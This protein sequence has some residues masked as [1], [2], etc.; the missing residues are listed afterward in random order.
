MTC[1]SCGHQQGTGKFC[2]KCGAKLIEENIHPEVAATVSAPVHSAATVNIPVQQ[3][4]PNEHLEKVKQQSKMYWSFFMTNLKNPSDIF[5]NYS[6]KMVNALITLIL[7]VG[8]FAL[9]IYRTYDV[10]IADAFNSFNSF[11][12]T[13]TGEEVSGPSFFG[14]FFALLIAFALV[15]LVVTLSLFLVNLFFGPKKSFMDIFTIFGTHLVP[16]LALTVLAY[17]LLLMKSFTI[18]NILLTL[19]L[20]VAFFL[21]PLFIISSLLSEKSHTIS[22]FYGFITYVVLFSIV[23]TFISTVIIDSVIGDYIEMI[24]DGLNW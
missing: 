19:A 2:G 11:S 3:S 4:Q 18:G 23:F 16:V 21:I 24:S 14:M 15:S 7:F 1:T 17:M 10:L 20:G 12:Q 6:G 9:G 13:L 22:R 5:Q 8:F